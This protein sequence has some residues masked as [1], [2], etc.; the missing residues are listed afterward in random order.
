ML[1]LLSTS[2]RV[3]RVRA[4]VR[5]VWETGKRVQR[6]HSPEAPAA[7]CLLAVTGRASHRAALKLVRHSDGPAVRVALMRWPDPS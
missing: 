5:N 4:P 7:S 2:V 3:S 6:A 1:I